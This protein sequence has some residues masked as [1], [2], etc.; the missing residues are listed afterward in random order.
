MDIRNFMHRLKTIYKLQTTTR[1]KK[2]DTEPKD[3]F[4]PKCNYNFNPER[5]SDNGTL[6]TFLHRVRLEMLN[7]DKY[8]QNKKDNLTKKERIALRD[9]IK[10]PHIVINKADKGS[11][12]VVEDRDEY[13]SNA[14]LHLND[15]IVYKPLDEDISPTLKESIMD[16][17]R[18]L[19]NN[20]LLKQ[21]WF[22]FCKPPKQIRTSRL[23]FLK[24][25]HENPMGIRPIVSSCDSIT[26]PISQ[27]VD[28]WLQPHV[29][30]LPSYLKD[31]TEFLN[32]IE[33][34]KLPHNCLLASIDVSSLYTNIPHED[35]IQNVLYYLQNNPDNYT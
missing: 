9:L 23:Y 6:D 1:R 15:P 26:E 4:T 16:K 33:T 3:P 19:R 10:N 32:P 17:L 24:K 11:T 13:I 21:P 35:G 20:G 5:L 27:F 30:N 31:S 29:K 8:K 18:L 7:V 14:M 12:I 28:R 25:I 2:K 22:E 34:T